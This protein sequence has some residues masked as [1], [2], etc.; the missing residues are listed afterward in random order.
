MV[1][2]QVGGLE[3]AKLEICLCLL[4]D[5]ATIGIFGFD[6]CLCESSGISLAQLLLNIMKFFSSD[7]LNRLLAKRCRK[8]AN[9]V[10]FRFFC[11]QLLLP[12][13]EQRNEAKR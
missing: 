8:I 1:I 7:S 6:A 4:S 9:D 10:S 5:N 11:I 12:W 13:S 3:D 2:F